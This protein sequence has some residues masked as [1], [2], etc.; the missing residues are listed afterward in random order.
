MNLH[1]TW[2]GN[3][4]GRLAWREVRD[5]AT[6][7]LSADDAGDHCLQFEAK[8]LSTGVR[9]RELAPVAGSR[10]FE[11]TLPRWR[12]RPAKV[13]FLASVDTTLE[14]GDGAN[15]SPDANGTTAVRTVTIINGRL[16]ALAIFFATLLVPLAAAGVW[17]ST[18]IAEIHPWVQYV[19]GAAIAALI[20]AI[21]TEI[22]RRPRHDALPFLGIFLLPARSIGAVA[23]TLCGL[24][25]VPRLA[26]TAIQ[27]E[28]HSKVELRNLNGRLPLEAGESVLSLGT[29]TRHGEFFTAIEGFSDS[30]E[31]WDGGEP[32]SA[33]FLIPLLGI[34]DSVIRC[35]S[36][37]WG[38]APPWSDGSPV[39]LE[40][41]EDCSRNV[42]KEVEVDAE[43]LTDML[44]RETEPNAP[45]AAHAT[46]SA[47]AML[48]PPSS[49]RFRDRT[50]FH[51]MAKGVHVA[52]LPSSP[53]SGPTGADLVMRGG[54][55]SYKRLLLH[56]RGATGGR[57]ITSPV[58]VGSGFATLEVYEPGSTHP[59]G[60][61]DCKF[62]PDTRLLEVV[63]IR[64][65]GIGALTISNGDESRSSWVS[66][67]PGAVTAWVCR[68]HGESLGRSTGA[69]ADVG[70]SKNHPPKIGLVLP[71]DWAPAMWRAIGASSNDPALACH[72]ILGADVEVHEA[73]VVGQK[74]G[75]WVR[76]AGTCDSTAW[77][78]FSHVNGGSAWVCS[79]V[80]GGTEYSAA[81]CE[82]VGPG[83]YDAKEHRFVCP[84]PARR[85]C[86]VN[87][88]DES[89]PRRVKS[90]PRCPLATSDFYA[91][92]G[93]AA[94]G[95]DDVYLCAASVPR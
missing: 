75:K 41:K 77:T 21:G 57:P 71:G 2:E 82:G 93:G 38:A 11:V 66:D 51:A 76:L 83:T 64:A 10:S 85:I 35:A 73:D 31:L 6:F 88:G 43:A 1:V 20:A 42:L 44:D 29:R 39:K 86:R 47:I 27:N 34:P 50:W 25:L 60:H 94:T 13:T 7:A 5:R 92:Y 4:D 36:P 79:D 91:N 23:A 52:L 62:A 80:C 58:A 32:A 16:T 9:C 59:L 68:A 84:P 69:V 28:T 81:S 18:H 17:L 55:G 3:S 48:L 90:S 15:A 49:D 33:P 19:N 24:L 65:E 45:R 53:A 8:S 30:F 63:A 67:E 70:A 72:H 89:H 87:E 61:L 78:S 22:R 46:T 26:L 14:G 40:V 95:C 54:D 37:V 12:L 56:A 74:D